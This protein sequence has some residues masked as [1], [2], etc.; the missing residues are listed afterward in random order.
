MV[1]Y[2]SWLLFHT[3]LV[4]VFGASVSEAPSCGL[5]GRAVTIYRYIS[6]STVVLSV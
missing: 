1:T 6:E 2:V 5:D 4:M 3:L